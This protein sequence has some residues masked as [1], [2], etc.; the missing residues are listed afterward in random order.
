MESSLLLPGL[1]TKIGVHVGAVHT[2]KRSQTSTAEEDRARNG[3]VRQGS[4]DGLI[5]LLATI[6]VLGSAWLFGVGE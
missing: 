2:A 3:L 1:S 4:W 6:K 5:L